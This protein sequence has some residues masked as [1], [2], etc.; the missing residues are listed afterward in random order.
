MDA[1]RSEIRVGL[2]WDAHPLVEGRPL[3]LGGVEIPFP[4][5]LQGHSD[6]DV[7]SHAVS[8]AL[9]GAAS[10]GDLG[11]HFPPGDPRFRGVRSLELLRQVVE[12]VKREGWEIVNVDAALIAQE[13]RLG[14]HLQQMKGRLS[15]AIGLPPTRISLKAKSPEGLGALGR[16]EGIAALAVAL[17]AK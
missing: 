7:L 13:P 17:I 16:A 3:V 5:G 10:L 1:P 15:E 4:K 6:A 8:D 9:L 12:M 11:G 14:P 2:G